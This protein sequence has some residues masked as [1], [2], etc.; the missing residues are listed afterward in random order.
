MGTVVVFQ[1]GGPEVTREEIE[2]GIIERTR[3]A[4]EKTGK[5]Q[6]D[7]AFALQIGHEQYR[8]YESRSPLPV[9]FVQAFCTIA[10]VEMD[11]LVTGRERRRKIVKPR[12]TA[13]VTE[14]KPRVVGRANR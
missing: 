2:Q 7:F 3:E 12:I 13:S 10:G 8:K 9:G 14:F 4:R 6:Q 11:W 5:T 1:K